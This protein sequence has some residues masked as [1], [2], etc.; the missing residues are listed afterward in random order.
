MKTIKTK[1]PDKLYDEIKGL[2]DSGWF[3]DEKDI[4][5][6]ALRRFLE[7]HKPDI[8]EKFLWE[9]VEWGLDGGD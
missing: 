6:E 9:D 5:N 3:Q 2:V 1:L 4:I 8:M 7:V